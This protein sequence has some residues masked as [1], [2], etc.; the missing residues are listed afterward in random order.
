MN[1]NKHDN[2]NTEP[3]VRTLIWTSIALAVAVALSAATVV[4]AAT[5]SQA[6]K[7]A[8]SLN[9]TAA[10]QKTAWQ[11]LSTPPLNQSAKD[12]DPGFVVPNS[13]QL[14]PMPPKA[15]GDLP[16]LKPYDFA[17]LH[18]KIVIVNPSDRVIA[19]VISG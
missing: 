9:L 2:P 13:V 15:A 12:V 1:A 5:M 3:P 19:E 18:H 8:D 10:Q 6:P 16:V 17:M 14:A 11:D 4:A 7:A